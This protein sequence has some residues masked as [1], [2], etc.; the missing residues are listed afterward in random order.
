M[1]GQSEQANQIEDSRHISP[2]LRWALLLGVLV[3]LSGFFI[4]RVISNP[5]PSREEEAAFVAFIST[6]IGG[7]EAELI[8]QASLFDS[9]PLFIPGE[10]ST[11]SEAF[12]FKDV[13]DWQVFPDF[14]PEMELKSRVWPVRL[15]RSLDA[16]VKKPIDLL[17]LR[18]WN[19]FSYFGQKEISLE[20]PEVWHSVA[21]VSV[22][23]GNDQYQVDSNIV[24]QADLEFDGFAPRPMIVCLNMSAP[25]FP[26]GSPLL[27]QS[28]GS[29]AVDGKVLEWLARPATLASLPT[30]F[31]ELRVFP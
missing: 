20:K 9:A 27:M 11:A 31:L 22:L 28:S 15:S 3:H 2:L 7:D 13:Q 10:W 14:E 16:E 30:G 23:S 29:D 25:G 1:S 18:F 21:V 5:L 12:Y 8:E 19:L 17:N 26:M 6:D 24:L 4:F